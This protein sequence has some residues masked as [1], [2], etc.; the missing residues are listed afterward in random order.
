MCSQYE[1][2]VPFNKFPTLL[3]KELPKDFEQNYEVQKLIRPNEPV[4]VLK[5]EGKI[6]TS[7]MLWG[8]I[9]EWT[10]D[11][12]DSSIFRPFNAKC[13]TVAEKKLFRASWRHKRCLIPATG[14]LEKGY[15]V[16]RVD[17][18][19]F[20]LGGLWNR[21]MSPEGSELESCCVLTTE[22][23]E[24]VR[25]LHDRMPVI[26]STGLEEEWIEP[27]KDS[28]ELKALEFL[29]NCSSPEEWIV[30]ELNPSI[31]YQTSLF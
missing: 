9:S 19:P 26:I 29:L 2:N 30:E 31:F 11:P 18:K 6:R 5:N 13:E 10:K 27:V 22:A 20:W 16:K 7:I 12:F 17:S 15:V 28:S 23:N 25:P 14:F 4:I 8:F 1:L 24:L 21:W 3:K